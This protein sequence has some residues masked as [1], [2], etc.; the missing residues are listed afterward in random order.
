[1][2]EHE[3]VSGELEEHNVEVE[4]LRELKRSLRSL[5]IR[6]AKSHKAEERIEH[7]ILSNR[8]KQYEH[9][10]VR[11]SPLG[12]DR[13]RRRYWWMD[14][15]LIKASARQ[16]ASGIILVEL[17][18]GRWAFYDEQEKIDQLLSFLSPNG[19]RELRLTQ[20]LTNLRDRIG[21]S[22]TSF[23]HAAI[24]SPRDSQ[25]TAS[26]GQEEGEKEREDYDDD[27]DMPM[28][29]RRRGKV[30]RLEEPGFLTYRNTFRPTTKKQR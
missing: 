13:F 3:Q 1:M 4:K 19:C 9:S 7:E 16:N 27:E 14:A 22:L 15:H 2:V 8:N 11:I 29:S 30:A 26:G 12:E 28:V 20:V 23:P 17:G 18:E 24:A 5:D 6:L 10:L 25:K 21:K